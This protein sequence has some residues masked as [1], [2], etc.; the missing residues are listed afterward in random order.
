MKLMPVVVFMKILV[1]L[2]FFFFLKVFGLY[3]VN[4]FSCIFEDDTLM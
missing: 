1:L 4:I 2:I 3:N